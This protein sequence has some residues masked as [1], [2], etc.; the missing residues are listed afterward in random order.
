MERLK[1]HGLRLL[2][3]VCLGA[4]AAA[5]WAALYYYRAQSELR[6]DPLQ[7]AYYARVSP[8][9]LAP[10]ERRV[11]FFGDSRSLQWTPPRGLTG[12]Q[13]VNR[14]IGHQ[15]TAQALARFDADVP[16]LKPDVVVLQVGVND[17]K[18]LPLF[19]EREREIVQR[20]T[21]NLDALVTRSRELGAEVI[22]V[23]IFPI[24]PVPLWRRPFWSDRVQAAVD[25]LNAH[26]ATL[27]GP[28]VRLLSADPV[29]LD[30]RR[31]M[32]AGYAL[33]H[34][35]LAPAA[36]ESINRER[37]IPLLRGAAN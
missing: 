32:R 17:L 24:G 34:L 25:E 26:L 31:H 33:D 9:A 27:A 15:T 7:L 22:L 13:W 20:A 28:G 18:T 2:V 37:L 16:K 5:A 1:R 6:L 11:V 14:G 35:H 23:T 29:L 30:E 21:R 12:F 8:P 36:Y 10:G 4:S 19:P 3:A